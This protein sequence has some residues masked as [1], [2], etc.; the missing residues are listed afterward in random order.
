[1]VKG[2]WVTTKG[3]MELGAAELGLGTGGAPILITF[4]W[5]SGL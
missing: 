4:C 3:L 5:A 1:M 2:T